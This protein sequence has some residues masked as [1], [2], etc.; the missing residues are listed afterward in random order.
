M[1]AKLV[2]GLLVLAFIIAVVMAVTFLY[3]KRRAELRHEKE[4]F[5]EKQRA[6]LDEQAL[7]IAEQESSLDAE[8]EE[9]DE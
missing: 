4:M 6:E 1:A 9:L 5:R 3:F 7:E 8:L 2:L